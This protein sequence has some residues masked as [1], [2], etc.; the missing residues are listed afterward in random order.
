M[1]IPT[2]VRWLTDPEWEIVSRVFQDT[3]PWRPRIFLT[4]GVALGDLAF[5]IPTSALSPL[6]VP[7]LMSTAFH[8]ILAGAVGGAGQALA[9]LLPAPGATP[10]AAQSLLSPVITV[11]AK[12]LNVAARLPGELLNIT[13][14]LPTM[15]LEGPSRLS[16]LYCIGYL[17]NVGPTGYAD[18]TANAGLQ[19]L[20]VHEMTHVWQGH[21]AIFAMTYVINS[22]YNQCKGMV[23][24]GFNGRLDAYSYQPGRW[25]KTYNAEQQ[26]HIVQ[27]WFDS[28]EPQ[29]GALWPYIRDNIRTGTT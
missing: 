23:V 18:M 14:G 10:N 1:R 24:N 2:R 28:G 17:M 21:N 12:V 3:L 7:A 5:T 4:N 19:S 13:G 15:V 16:S 9:A 29:S 22:A 26:A 25:F 27:D 11:D 8:G 20:L 6:A